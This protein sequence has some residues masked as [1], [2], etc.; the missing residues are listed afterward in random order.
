MIESVDHQL[1]TQLPRRSPTSSLGHNRKRNA[2]PAGDL[3]GHLVQARRT[4]GVRQSSRESS[5]KAQSSESIPF[6]EER[7][8]SASHISTSRNESLRLHESHAPKAVTENEGASLNGNANSRPSAVQANK[9]RLSLKLLESEVEP[10][11]I[12]EQ[13]SP[14]EDIER[15]D[16]PNTPEKQLNYSLLEATQ[17]TLRPANPD[18][19]VVSATVDPWEGMTEIRSI[20]VIVPKDQLELLNAER[21]PWYPPPVGEQLLSGHVPPA[22]LDEW[23]QLVLRR[24]QEESDSSQPM[25]D[26]FSKEPS[27][28]VSG[29]SSEV[30]DGNSDEVLDSDW[31]ETPNRT[32][33]RGLIL[34]RNPIPE[35]TPTRKSPVPPPKSQEVSLNDKG[36]VH[37][38]TDPEQRDVQEAAPSSPDNR[39]RIF[40]L[41]DQDAQK[42]GS[43]SQHQ[44]LNADILKAPEVSSDQPK[45]GDVVPDIPCD[46]DE[47]EADYM[48]TG[49]DTGTSD[50]SSDSEMEVV[51]PQP[52][53]GS[54][55]GMSSQAEGISSSGASLPEVARQKIQVVE[56]PAAALSKTHPEMINQNTFQA[57]TEIPSQ[58]DKSSSQSRVLNTYPSNDGDSKEEALQES[59]RSVPATAPEKSNRMHVMGTPL[60]NEAPQ[61]EPTPWSETDTPFTS[62]GPKVVQAS[63]APAAST[64]Q[65]QSSKAFSSYRDL[66]PSSMLSMDDHRSPSIQ[67]LARNTPLKVDRASPLKRFAS[68]IG[69]SER[70]SPSK[71]IKV[72]RK[73]TPYEPNK[74][75]DRN[76]FIRQGSITNPP[77]SLSA[78][79][80]YEN[81]CAVYPDYAGDFEHFMG[82]CFRL[83][84]FREGG[85]L[86]RPYLWDDFIIKHLTDYPQYITECMEND[87]K[88][89]KYEEYFADSFSIPTCTKRCLLP[90]RIN[91]C[92]VEFVAVGGS[93]P[94]DSSWA[95]DTRISFTGSLRD[96]LS[97]FHAHSFAATPTQNSSQ[98]EQKQSD[99]SETSSELSIPDSEPARVAAQAV[100][101]E[102]RESNQTRETTSIPSDW[103]PS[104]EEMEDADNEAD[105]DDTIH[106]T[107]SVE[108]GDEEDQPEPEPRPTPG[109]P[110]RD[111][112]PESPDAS[113]N[114]S[115]AAEPELE[116]ESESEVVPESQ[117]KPQESLILPHPDIP[118]DAPPPNPL[119]PLQA[120]S[121]HEPEAPT[122]SN[123]EPTPEPEDEDENENWFTSLRHITLPLAEPT[124]SDDPNTPFKQWVRRDQDVLIVRNRRGGV[125]VECDGG[126]V[127]RFQRARE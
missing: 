4:S 45:N 96:K 116:T 124:W 3:L 57:N 87:T 77:Q 33:S 83:R 114:K 54:T 23:N 121:D 48:S 20:D 79:E 78:S 10:P 55:Q 109:K 105:V 63:I 75:E 66:P 43:P 93:E 97:N 12:A 88:P 8:R 62:S 60:D 126:V 86:Q 44:D 31:Y 30:S 53:S 102:D 101:D 51:I 72:D 36:D 125:R 99:W 7:R 40:D 59:S 94:I 47:D 2:V 95:A 5:A 112:I 69:D 22:L 11:T 106:E 19:D 84:A 29:H 73:S 127:K 104:D 58:P 17:M 39:T 103:M 98:D 115:A 118:I 25:D 14:Q 38:T 108:L 90:G 24:H 119:N 52:L 70:G 117:G 100:L 120:E 81:F 76:K 64:Y 21:K 34:A 6:A 113:A 50:G 26:D 61:T 85:R 42:D 123:A 111:S 80:I 49:S 37:K 74:L 28:P 122:E 9:D 35:D 32:P 82:L 89:V 71:R 15:V 68:E 1:G 67:S 27:T 110:P 18:K 56:T 107:A 91:T 65:S 46:G 16:S 92:A 13:Q 41:G